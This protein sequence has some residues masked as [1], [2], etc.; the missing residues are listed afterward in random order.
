MSIYIDETFKSC[1]IQFTQLF[2]THRM[3]NNNYVLLVFYLLL[4]KASTTYETSFQLIIS[5]C[6]KLNF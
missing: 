6:Q 2:T 5:E 4:D 3:K 1:P